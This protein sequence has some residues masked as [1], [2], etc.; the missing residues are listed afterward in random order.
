MRITHQMLSRN[1]LKRMNTNLR[2]LT[3]S[4]EKLSSQRAFNKGYENVSD[5]GKAL[6]MRKMLA[7][8]ERYQTAVRDA[9]GRAS[10]AEDSLMTVSGL[11]NKIQDRVTEGL[12]GTV[13]AG[14]RQKI[15]IEIEKLQDEVF[16]M[17]NMTFA[18]KHVFAAAGNADGS[19]PFTKDT[20]GDLIFNGTK[21]DDMV[22]SAA[23]GRPQVWDAA[24]SSYV[25]IPYNETNYIDIGFGYKIIPDGEPGAGRVNP[26]TAFKDTYSGAESFGFGVNADGVPLNAYSLLGDIAKNLRANDEDAL[27]KNLGAIGGTMD[28]ML[29][30][31]TEI[32]A[33]ATTLED[34]MANLENEY[35]N[36]AEAQNELEGIDLSKEIIFNKDYEMSW[37]VTLQ[38][39]SRI[40]PQTIFDFLR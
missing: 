27:R 2:S 25:D 26:N 12:N 40:L 38:L 10:A 37:L 39:G 30:S 33:R 34:T 31:I 15:A 7:D 36:L 29:T 8:N 3:N 16:Q 14:D 11:L 23:T 17:M 6:K 35:I 1:Y 4:N 9:E 28:A 19:A 21:V 13:N 32:G 18:G 20:N 5:A 22:A 24:S